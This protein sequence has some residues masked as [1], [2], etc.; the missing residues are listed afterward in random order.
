MASNAWA[1]LLAFAATGAVATWLAVERASFGAAPDDRTPWWVL[2]G[3]VFVGA[4]AGSLRRASYRQLFAAAIALALLAS[5][6]ARGASLILLLWCGWA[7]LLE[8]D[9]R[10]AARDRGAHYQWLLGATALMCS[11]NVS[12][13]VL[14]YEHYWT[15]LCLAR[16]VENDLSAADLR[17]IG[18]EVDTCFSSNPFEQSHQADA[19][20]PLDLGVDESNGLPVELAA[21]HDCTPPHRLVVRY[22]DITADRCCATRGDVFKSGLASNYAGCLVPEARDTWL[23]T[24][25]LEASSVRWCDRSAAGSRAD[26]L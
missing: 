7:L 2:L 18:A 6:G 11:A 25:G 1:L 23:T 14:R 5:S 4:V 8:A 22:R 13:V 12:V 15:R 3:S 24:R 20:L 16:F 10:G 19:V 26:P 17:R 21:S 9:R